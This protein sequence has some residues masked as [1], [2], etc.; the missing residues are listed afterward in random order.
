M[1]RDAHVVTCQVLN[2][3]AGLKPALPVG[4]V[5]HPRPHTHGSNKCRPA[6]SECGHVD[7]RDRFQGGK[8]SEHEEKMGKERPLVA[9]AGLG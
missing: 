7:V 3:A 4:N 6:G 1:E 5:R 8:A 9:C 2:G